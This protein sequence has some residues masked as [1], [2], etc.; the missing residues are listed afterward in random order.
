MTK[1]QHVI[2]MASQ[3]ARNASQR[4]SAFNQ[5][6]SSFRFARS[7]DVY[8]TNYER[9]RDCAKILRFKYSS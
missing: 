1:T 9:S 5:G 6:R 4:V 2:P 3:T 7:N 8:K